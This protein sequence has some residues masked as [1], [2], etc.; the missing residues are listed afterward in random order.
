MA[1]IDSPTPRSN[2]FR[3]LLIREALPHFSYKR[4]Q[5][6]RFLNCGFSEKSETR[7]AVTRNR[8]TLVLGC[9]TSSVTLE[10]KLHPIFTHFEKSQG[11][12]GS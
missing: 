2:I 3:R 9:K 6:A 4:P 7:G 8:K 10:R 5:A 11:L 12:L 1:S